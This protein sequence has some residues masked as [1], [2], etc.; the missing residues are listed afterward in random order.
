MM[1]MFVN[2]IFRVV[3]FRKFV[4][5]RSVFNSVNCYFGCVI[6]SGIFGSFVL[7][8]MFNMCVVL[9]LI[10]LFVLLK[11]FSSVNASFACDLSIFFVFVVFVSIL[12]LFLFL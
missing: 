5:F 11:I 6:V 2:L 3:V 7:L 12:C 1:F 10:V 9:F 4:R 8:L